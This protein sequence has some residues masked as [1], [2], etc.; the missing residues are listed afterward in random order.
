MINTQN[1]NNV[2]MCAVLLFCD[3]TLSFTYH[4]S[5]VDVVVLQ[6]Y[7]YQAHLAL[8]NTFP[9]HCCHILAIILLAPLSTH[10]AHLLPLRGCGVGDWPPS[11][12]FLCQTPIIVIRIMQNW[13]TY[14]RQQT[15]IEQFP[16]LSSPGVTPC[17][18]TGYP[19]EKKMLNSKLLPIDYR[20]WKVFLSIFKE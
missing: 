2:N 6:C 8:Y 10:C 1:A 12:P 16:C 4:I 7:Q 5:T 3:L 18:I 11:P 20:V 13:Y 15:H 14:Y 19:H 17:E 9:A